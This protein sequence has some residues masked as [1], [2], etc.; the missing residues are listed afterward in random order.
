MPG[1]CRNVTQSLRQP[2]L[3]TGA[4]D[5]HQIVPPTFLLPHHM[6][7]CNSLP[8]IASEDGLKWERTTLGICSLTEGAGE[9]SLTICLWVSLSSIT[10]LSYGSFLCLSGAVFLGYKMTNGYSG[11][12]GKQIWEFEANLVYS[13]TLRLEEHFLFSLPTGPSDDSVF[14]HSPHPPSTH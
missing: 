12:R 11:G 10:R 7:T 14:I 8:P 2:D 5:I 1:E 3:G 4:S 9:T 13:E 6:P